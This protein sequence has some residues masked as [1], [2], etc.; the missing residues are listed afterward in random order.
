MRFRDA[1]DPF[2]ALGGAWTLVRRAPAVILTGGLLLAIFDSGASFGVQFTHEDWEIALACAHCAAGLV[3]YGLVSFFSASFATAV[4]RVAVQG[5]ER[6]SDLFRVR[7]RFWSMA[8]GRLLLG[9][10]LVAACVPFALVAGV[11]G[12]MV[13]AMGGEE[14]GIAVGVLTFLLLS[15]GLIYV[16][17]GL[18]LAPLAIAFER[19]G[20]FDAVTRSWRLVAG[21]RLWLFWF[22]LVMFVFEV[23]GFCCCFVGILAT[24]TFSQIAGYEAYLRLVRDDHELWAVEGGAGAP[25]HS[26]APGEPD[27]PTW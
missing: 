11:V 14:A 9:L 8:L 5:Q 3:Y 25:L 20:P 13:A 19:L 16:V 2:R 27:D 4:E 26:V 12:F 23:L 24:G 15:P 18:V 7:G 10:L 22:L 1:F 17:L 6:M 21:N